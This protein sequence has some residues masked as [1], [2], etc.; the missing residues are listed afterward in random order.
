MM[1][2]GILLC[3]NVIQVCD[4]YLNTIFIYFILFVFNFSVCGLKSTD[5][6]PLI[7]NG[8]ATKKGEY[9]WMIGLYNEAKSHICG[10][11][12]I[13]PEITLTAAHCINEVN[14]PSK[15]FV[16]AGKYYRTYNDTRDKIAQYSN[17][18]LLICIL[19]KILAY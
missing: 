17:V 18:R 15:Y 13:T 6:T 11:S 12:M 7:I 9:P 14:D 16:A 5:A 3:H 19:Y 4:F 10:G 8:K 1:D 2:P